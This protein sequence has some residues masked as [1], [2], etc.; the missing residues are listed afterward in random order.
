MRRRAEV[1]SRA[2]P[3]RF[4][5]FICP[6]TPKP[7]WVLFLENVEIAPSGLVRALLALK[8]HGWF[9]VLAGLMIGRSKGPNPE[10]ATSLSY[11]EALRSVLS[12][13]R[14]AVLFDVDIGH[15]PPS[16]RS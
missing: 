10:S 1:L 11:V 6:A 12:E 13:L 9:D 14:Y 16:S 5:P 3:D 7:R 4:A 15:Q 8:R 2:V